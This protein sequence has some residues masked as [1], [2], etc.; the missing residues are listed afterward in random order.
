M[1]VSTLRIEFY[2]IGS[3][4]LNIPT[5][6]NILYIKDF[7]YKEVSKWRGEVTGNYPPKIAIPDH[8]GFGK[9]D[10]SYHRGFVT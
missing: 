8:R 5:I 3:L 10:F 4:Q 2:Y 1:A 7:Q 9:F 6:S